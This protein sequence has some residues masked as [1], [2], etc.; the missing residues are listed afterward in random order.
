MDRSTSTYTS[1]F[2]LGAVALMTTTGCGILDDAADSIS[3]SDLEPSPSLSGC[4]LLE[5]QHV[6]GGVDLDG[7]YHIVSHRSGGRSIRVDHGEV[8]I[9]PGSEFYFDSGEGIRFLQDSGDPAVL[10]AEGTEEEPILFSH[11]EDNASPGSWDGLY[12][13]DTSGAEHVLDHVIIE[14]GG[15]RNFGTRSRDNRQG[16]L[17][18]DKEVRL[19]ATNVTLRQNDHAGLAIHEDYHDQTFGNITIEDTAGY[20]LRIRA[21]HV[22]L[23]NDSFTIVDNEHQ[24]I[25]VSDNHSENDRDFTTDGTWPNIGLPYYVGRMEIRGDMTLEPGLTLYMA[26]DSSSGGR[27]SVREGGSLH[28]VGTA[29]EPIVFRGDIPGAGFWDDIR[30]DDSFSDRNEFQHVEIRDAEHGLRV[31]GFSKVTIN[32]TLFANMSRSVLRVDSDSE[33]SGCQGLSFQDVEGDE[34]HDAC[35]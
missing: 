9:A 5:Q 19:T 3:S 8:T 12:F 7:C 30:L 31:N 10:I 34:N 14:Q 2:A 25:R 16:G 17:V 27:W 20:P 21:N 35:E 4:Y 26:S 24:A 29:E 13:E 33:V 11:Y 6:N 28:A 32:D 23:L 15:G 18:L 1:L 22:P